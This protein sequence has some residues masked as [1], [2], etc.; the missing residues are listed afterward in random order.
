MYV[1]TTMA[2]IKVITIDTSTMQVAIMRV[3]ENIFLI[4][5]TGP[6]RKQVL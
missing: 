1:C 6:I 5:L 3:D 4:W 2:A